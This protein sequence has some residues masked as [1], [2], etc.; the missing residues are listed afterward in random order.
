MGQKFQGLMDPRRGT[1]LLH[2]HSNKL[3]HGF[4]FIL[5]DSTSIKPRTRTSFCGSWWSVKRPT[6]GQWAKSEGIECS[7]LIGTS[8]THPCL[9]RLIS[10]ESWEDCK[11]QSSGCI[12]QNSLCWTWQGHCPQAHSNYDWM[13]K[14]YP[15]SNQS[16][17]QHGRG[18]A[19]HSLWSCCQRASSLQGHGPEGLNFSRGW[20]CPHAYIGR[21]W[22]QWTVKAD[23]MK[24]VRRESCGGYQRGIGGMVRRF[25]QIRLY[26]RTTVS[27]KLK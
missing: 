10:G 26:L 21:K 16:Q 9:S 24:L 15:R 8:R 18:R 17:S 25:D 1:I 7:A 14:R 19:H 4:I 27:K 2:G 20:F 3:P 6:T 22:T 12:H 11:S 5:T 23:H 13:H